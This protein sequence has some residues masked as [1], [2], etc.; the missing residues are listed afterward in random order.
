MNWKNSWWI[1]EQWKELAK[2]EVKKFL[3]K[4]ILLWI[5]SVFLNFFIFIVIFSWI[6]VI[7]LAIYSTISSIWWDWWFNQDNWS[8]AV[9]LMNETTLL[10]WYKND[11]PYWWPITWQAKIDVTLAD[12]AT[13]SW[14]RLTK[15]HVSSAIDMQEIWWTHW[16]EKHVKDVIVK[17]MSWDYNNVS[18]FHDWEQESEEIIEVEELWWN[19]WRVEWLN[20][21]YKKYKSDWDFSYF[22]NFKNWSSTSNATWVTWRYTYP[23]FIYSTISWTVRNINSRSWCFSVDWQDYAVWFCHYWDLNISEWDEVWAWQIL[24]TMWMRW[25]TFWAHIHYEI[26]EYWDSSDFYFI[27][28]TTATKWKSTLKANEMK[29]MMLW[30]KIVSDWKW[31]YYFDH[32]WTNIQCLQNDCWDNW[33]KKDLAWDHDWKWDETRPWELWIYIDKTIWIVKQN[34]NVKENVLYAIFEKEWVPKDRSWPMKQYYLAAD[35]W[36]WLFQLQEPAKADWTIDRDLVKEYADY[37]WTVQWFPSMSW[38]E[39]KTRNYNGTWCNQW[40]TLWWKWWT[41]SSPV[42]AY[43]EKSHYLFPWKK[44][45]YKN[46]FAV[47]SKEDVL[48]LWCNLERDRRFDFND[49]IVIFDKKIWDKSASCDHLLINKNMNAKFPSWKEYTRDSYEFWVCTVLAYNWFTARW[50]QPYFFSHYIKFKEDIENWKDTLAECNRVAPKTNC[51]YAYEYAKRY[52][53]AQQNWWNYWD[54]FTKDSKWNWQEGSKHKQKVEWDKLKNEKDKWKNIEW[55]EN[56][57]YDLETDSSLTKFVWKEISFKDKKY[58]PQVIKAEYWANL[59]WDRDH[60]WRKEAID[61][62]NKAA[63]QFKKDN[64]EKMYIVSSYRSYDYQ[65]KRRYVDWCKPE[66][67]AEPWFSEHQTWLTFD[68]WSASNES[69]WKSDKKLAK[70]YEWMKKNMHKYWFTQSYLKWLS[71]DWYNVEPWHWR[72]VWIELATFL[73][74]KDLSFTQ[75]YYWIKK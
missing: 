22:R 31:M 63:E 66:D 64:W 18:T 75:Y 59:S 23:F 26:A 27:W 7:W 39:V 54:Y 33:S 10:W 62:L 61:A 69:T 3:S 29:Q 70:R 52:I 46:V 50:S 32:V 34:H 11:T 73:K 60:F 43:Y 42:W 24:W 35:W 74:E 4:K 15:F 25:H 9:K 5:W 53:K 47:D 41:Q 55:I 57:K 20:D 17:I 56:H 30:W 44:K 72:Y 51:W 13:Y 36:V 19:K 12:H 8:I 40:Y 49:A 58:V 65:H 21:Q 67:C 38:E 1:K 71:I 2:Q 45:H 37:V 6:F 48:K 68:L 28:S 16:S 14:Y